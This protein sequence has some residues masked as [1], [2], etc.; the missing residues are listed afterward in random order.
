M[1]SVF[2][3]FVKTYSLYVLPQHALTRVVYWLTRR[4]SSMTPKVIHWFAGK[5][6][7]DMRDAANSDLLNPKRDPS[8]HRT[9]A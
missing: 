9:T 2:S 3:D 6:N 4:Q 7:V 8:L 5:F 1:P